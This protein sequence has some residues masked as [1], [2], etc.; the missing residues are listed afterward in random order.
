MDASKVVQALRDGDFE[1]LVL[2]LDTDHLMVFTPEEGVT[3]TVAAF[4]KAHVKVYRQPDSLQLSV[5]SHEPDASQCHATMVEMTQ[6]ERGLA[7][8][9]GVPVG[10]LWVDGV[11]TPAPEAQ[12]ASIFA[13]IERTLG[14]RPSLVTVPDDP[15]ALF[16]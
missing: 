4:G 15:G 11:L 16:A 3:M 10:E 1:A 13:M 7:L 12:T 2:A 9:H 6:T 5:H 14:I 8:A